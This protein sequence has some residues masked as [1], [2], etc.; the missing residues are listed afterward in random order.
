MRRR[1]PVQIVG[2][3]AQVGVAHEFA[4]VVERAAGL[5]EAMSEGGAEGVN[6]GMLADSGGFD[7]LRDGALHAGFVEVMTAQGLGALVVSNVARGK[8]VEEQQRREGLVLS[9]GRDFAIYSQV[10]EEGGEMGLAQG[11]RVLKSVKNDIFFVP[12]DVGVF[13]AAGIAA[14]ADGVAELVFES[15]GGHG[16]VLVEYLGS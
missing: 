7:G 16:G 10:G 6:G 3:G 2:S 1:G 13:G 12:M 14:L 5:V 11:R 9:G 4:N 15:F 8:A